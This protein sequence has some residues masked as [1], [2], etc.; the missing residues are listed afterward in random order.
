MRRIADAHVDVLWRMLE[1][2]ECFYGDSRLQASYD[3]LRGSGVATQV[4]ALYVDPTK[5]PTSQLEDV[6]RS[7]DLFYRQVVADGRVRAVRSRAELAQARERGE[8]AAVLSIEG[9]GCLRGQPAL[10]RVMHDLGV[11]GMGLTWN[12]ANELADGCREP[13]GG[14]L[15]GAGLAVVEEMGRLGMWIDLA[16][17]ADQGVADVF[18]RT[19][20]PVL[21]SH[22]NCRS[23]H[24]HPRNLTDDVIRELIAR[25]GWMGMVFEGSF[26]AQESALSVDAVFKHM[27]HVLELGGEDILGLGSDFDGTSHAVPGLTD[28]SDYAAFADQ[29]A[30]RYGEG[31]AEKILF[32]N[33]ERF[34]S[35]VL[36]A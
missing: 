24:E 36:P 31:L 2:D 20:G 4:F 30:A 29:L 22:A 1:R 33:F 14:G 28:A 27:D 12:Y 15:T 6:L 5:P 10:L 19:D 8:L 11:R 18:A 3:K 25:R 21:A 23:V 7:L 13:R 9:G 32:A 17:L 34:L 35:D 16:H 26:V